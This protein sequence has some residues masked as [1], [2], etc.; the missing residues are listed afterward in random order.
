MT[1]DYTGMFLDGKVFDSSIGKPAPFTFQLGGGTVIPGW[2]YGVA[3]MKV[4]GKRI[5]FIPPNLAYGSA[6]HPPAIPANSTLFFAIELLAV[7]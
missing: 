4:G 2:D 6:G 5:L 7:Q 1:V 3:G